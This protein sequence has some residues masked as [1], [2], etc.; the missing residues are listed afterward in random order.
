MLYTYT[1]K[2]LY[3][4]FQLFDK[5]QLILKLVNTLDAKHPPIRQLNAAE[6]ICAIELASEFHPLEQN[7]LVISIES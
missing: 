7:P 3:I 2:H 1:N 6:T 4:F 5:E